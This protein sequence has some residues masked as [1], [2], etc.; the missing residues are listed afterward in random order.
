MAS[1]Q[2]WLFHTGVVTLLLMSLGP[3][4]GGLNSEVAALR[5]DFIKQVSLWSLSFCF[6]SSTAGPSKVK[7]TVK[8]AAA[9]DPE[10]ELEDSHHVLE[11]KGVI[12]NAVLNMV[13]I[14]KGTNSYYKLQVLESDGGVLKR[15]CVFRS[16]GRVGTTIGGTKLDVR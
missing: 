8:G 13:D 11:T 12:W 10:S 16:W 1:V 7:V 5:G 3:K 2:R 4:E 14:T 6:W 9:V 15:Y